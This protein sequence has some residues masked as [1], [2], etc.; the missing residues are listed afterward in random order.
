MSATMAER[1]TRLFVIS[2][3][4]KSL[5]DLP[6][7]AEG[8]SVQ[9][10]VEVP[11]GGQIKLKYDPTVGVFR[12]VRP[13]VAGLVYPHDWGFVPS[14]RG[15]DGDPLDGMVLHQGTTFPGAVIGCR[16]LCVL[17][18]EQQ[19][20]G[21]KIRN[22]RYL[23]CPAEDPSTEK[24]ADLDDLVPRVREELERFFLAAVSN[25]EKKLKLLG[26]KKASTAL[27]GLRAGTKAFAKHRR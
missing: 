22:D 1:P 6:A 27:I 19:E 4:M 25:T 7:F 5:I 13:L 8:Q 21:K 10:V 11:R 24:L 17:Q 23:F 2:F 3:T 9:V 12:Y 16:L 15:E 14:T 26:W 20:R 18:V